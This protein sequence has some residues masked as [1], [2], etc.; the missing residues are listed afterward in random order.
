MSAG[1]QP[2]IGEELIRIIRSEIHAYDRRKDE[3]LRLRR[4]A[5]EAVVKA[6][7][8][9][10]AARNSTPDPLLAGLTG[11]VNAQAIDALFRRQQHT[12]VDFTI[13]GNKVD[14]GV[15]QR[16]V[17][18]STTADTAKITAWKPFGTGENL[19]RRRWWQRPKN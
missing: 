11:D 17:P 18:D 5:D 14:R 4:V 16:A 12:H 7:H 9:A 8:A 10:E 1:K 2:S 15:V 13:G 19:P 3:A 6:D